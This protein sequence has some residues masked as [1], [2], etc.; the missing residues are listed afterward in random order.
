MVEFYLKLLVG[1]V[2]G[3][4]WVL[5]FQCYKILRKMEKKMKEHKTCKKDNPNCFKSKKKKVILKDGSTRNSKRI[6]K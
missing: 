2:I 5:S 3:S 1:M 4:T 6:K